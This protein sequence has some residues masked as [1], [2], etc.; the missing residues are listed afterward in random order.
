MKKEVINTGDIVYH[1]T[2]VSPML[3]DNIIETIAICSWRNEN[4]QRVTGEFP[5]KDI[6][7]T[8]PDN[9]PLLPYFR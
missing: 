8:M 6:S 5:L 3:V 1:L 4:G 7:K 2:S 9:T